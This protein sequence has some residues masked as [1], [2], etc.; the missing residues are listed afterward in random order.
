MLLVPG[1]P[2]HPRRADPH[3]A[4]QADAA[5]DLGIAVARIDHDALDRPAVAVTGVPADP[6]VLYRGWMMTSAEYAQIA[7]ALADRGVR[8]RTSADEYRTAHELPGWY[9]ALSPVT[10]ESTWTVG[11]D[12]GELVAAA[13]RLGPGPAVLRDYVKSMKHDWDEAAYIPDLADTESLQRVAKRFLE[14]RADSFTGGFVV[15]RF[16]EFTGAEARTWWIGGRCRLITPHPDTP[17]ELPIGLDLVEIEPLVAELAL[18]F[19]TVD[20]VRRADGAWRVV[21]L[22]DG[23]VSDWPSSRDPAALLAALY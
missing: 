8:L 7:A 13:G 9:E 15:R 5:R 18:P 14:L 1:D 22:G 4:A 2:L 3:F 6:D 21:E 17:D 12:P 16:E 23:Q 19:V 11:T 20:V 10:P